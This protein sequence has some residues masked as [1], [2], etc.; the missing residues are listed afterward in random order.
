MAWLRE[1]WVKAFEQLECSDMAR[2]KEQI[3]WKKLDLSLARALQGMVKSSGESLS[4]DVTMKAREFAQKDNIFRGRQIIWMMIDNFKTNRSLQEQCT[5][6]DIESLQWPGDERLQWL[7]IRWK[8]I[9][10]SLSITMP[11]VVLRDT[12][13]S[14][15][16]ALKKLPV[17]IVEFDRMREDDD[18][19]TLKWLTEGTDRLL[20][21]ERTEWARKLQKKSLTSGAIDA[22]SVPGQPG[23]G[24][25]GGKKGKGKGKGKGMGKGRGQRDQSRESTGSTKTKGVCHMYVRHG[26]RSN[27]DCPYFTF[28]TGPS[29]ACTWA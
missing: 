13:L 28:G 21:R 25:G 24:K 17:D 11:E 19:R 14:K 10:N 12:F 22:D 9:A 6:Q 7:Y 2:A 18:R 26:Q 3:R 23:A 4:E 16:R 27:D 8:L 5:W 15:V 1:C 29:K 20:A